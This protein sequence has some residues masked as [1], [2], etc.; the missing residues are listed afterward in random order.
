[1]ER[2]AS[3]H[4]L[5]STQQLIDS[6]STRDSAAQSAFSSRK[7]WAGTK[8]SKLSSHHGADMAWNLPIW[9]HHQR[10]Q[11]LDNKHYHH[12]H[13]RP[14]Q[15]K[16]RQGHRCLRT[17]ATVD[18]TTCPPRAPTKPTMRK[19]ERQQRQQLQLG[20]PRPPKSSGSRMI[21]RAFR[22][23]NYSYRDW[24]INQETAPIAFKARTWGTRSQQAQNYK[25]LS[26]LT[27]R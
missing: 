18:N 15:H 21:K 4:R 14:R 23:S 12:Q 25:Q 22:K 3:S 8:A 26:T 6:W 5:F 13:H 10:W 20:K 7:S 17:I 16:Y 11:G 19:K 9:Y 27:N 1:M 24:Q 2:W